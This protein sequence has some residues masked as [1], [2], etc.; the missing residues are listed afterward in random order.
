MG[1]ERIEKHLLCYFKW[2][3]HFCILSEILVEIEKKRAVIRPP[4]FRLKLILLFI[5][6]DLLIVA[7]H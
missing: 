6:N 1:D 2:H 5:Y 7:A 4:F 3:T